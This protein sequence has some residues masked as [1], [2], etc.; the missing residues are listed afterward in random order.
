[1]AASTPDRLAQLG[2]KPCPD[3]EFTCVTLSVPLDHFDPTDARRIDVVFAVLPA[4]GKPKGLFVTAT[5]GPG[6]AGISY[7][8]SYTS[9]FAPSIRRSFD[10]VFFDQRGIGLSGGLTCPEAA[11]TYYASQDPP[12]EAASRFSAECVAA[13]GFS[14]LLPFVGTA[15]AIEDLEDFRLALGGPRM[16]LYGESYGTQYAQEY[17]AAHPDALGGLVLDGTVDLTLDGPEFWADAAGAF[18][19]VLDGTLASCDRNPACAGDAG[20]AA[21]AVYDG[22]RSRLGRRSASV[23][24]PL[25][26]GGFAHRSLAA[27]DLATIASS[28]MYTEDDRMLFQ[29]ALA[30]AGRGQLVPLVR[31]LYADLYVDPQ[32]LE[33][34][35]DPSYSDG[36]YYGVDCQDYAY[37]SGTPAERASQYLAAAVPVAARYPRVGELVFLSDLACAFWPDAAQNR[38]RP[39]PLRAEGVPTLVLA[40]TGDPITPVG[41]GE[42]V[43]RRLADGYLIETRGGPH[44]TFGRGNACPDTF[45]TLFL[46]NGALPNRRVTC[47]GRLVAPYV[48]LAPA[49]AAAFSSAREALASAETEIEYLP[50]FYYWGAEEPGKAGCP[51]GGG[52]LRFSPT[53]SGARLTLR[54]CGFSSGLLFDGTGSY[55]WDADRFE[56]DV[57]ASGRFR[58]SFRYVRNGARTTV[59]RG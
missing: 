16:W 39:A 31:L 59:T 5:G 32:T 34:V 46:V 7:A 33:P 30:A 42:D 8:D 25:P 35:P 45:V 49:R 2:G 6:S 3:S 13:M 57:R 15:Q 44:V 52:T 14:P 58:G 21:A 22:L 37:Y 17:A 11:T 48:P 10:I 54:R 29:R 28:Q 1:V 18:E 47:Q 36:M 9:A 26:S 23:R 55:D 24:F 41:E 50:E 27:G 19:R 4:L 56:L 38:P 20:E 12:A 40:A 43:Y 53:D 51:Y